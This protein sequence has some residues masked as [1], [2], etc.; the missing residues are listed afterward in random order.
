[1]QE[2]QDP[3]SVREELLERLRRLETPQ[4]SAGL[5]EL[6]YRRAR[7]A[8]EQAL[9]ESRRIRIEAIETSRLTSERETAALMETLRTQRH[10]AETQ[11]QAMLQAAGLEAEQ[12]RQEAEHEA[13]R[14]A[15]SAA[16]EAANVR[17][18]ALTLRSSLEERRREIERLEADFNAL[19]EEIARRLGVVEKPKGGWFSRLLR[20]S[21]KGG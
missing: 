13:H 12:R 17:Q 1:M 3:H 8:L 19:L 14:I 15:E 7:E 9:E 2:G 4:P 21:S 20:R 18:E 6:A 5:A 10:A 16:A 11:V